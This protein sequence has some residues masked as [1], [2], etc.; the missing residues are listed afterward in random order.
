MEA[1]YLRLEDVRDLVCRVWSISV[2]ELQSDDRGK[3]MPDARAAFA[4]LS[5]MNTGKS[6]LRIA[7]AAGMVSGSAARA[8][9]CRYGD[10][11]DGVR[12]SLESAVFEMKRGRF[13]GEGAA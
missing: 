9:A 1:V 10:L 3:P 13:G 12:G 6:W 11:P 5:H 2:D 4:W 7:R 8:A